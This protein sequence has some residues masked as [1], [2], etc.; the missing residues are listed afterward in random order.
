MMHEEF[1]DIEADA[2]RTDH[3]DFLAYRFA[4]E[5]HIEVAQHLV[6]LD[7]RNGWQARGN[8]SSQDDLIE[9]AVDQLLHTY[10]GVEA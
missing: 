4:F 6:V 7:A 1:R 9:S 2:T 10:T 3:R 5:Q 8:T